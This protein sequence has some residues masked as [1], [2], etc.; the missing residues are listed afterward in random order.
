MQNYT[1]EF[2]KQ[3]ESN[4]SPREIYSF[5][6]NLTETR[7]GGENLDSDLSLRYAYFVLLSKHSCQTRTQVAL[8]HKVAK[9]RF[10]AFLRN[11]ESIIYV[12]VM[13][14]PLPGFILFCML[15]YGIGRA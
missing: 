14:S 13:N 15:G 6:K 7:L 5:R 9:T 2:P 10:V 4:E 8:I 11:A 1:S 12:L 3:C